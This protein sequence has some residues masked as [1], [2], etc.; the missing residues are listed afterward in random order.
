M[1]GGHHLVQQ[2]LFVSRRA[3]TSPAPAQGEQI[4]ARQAD[5][6]VR[7]VREGAV[8]FPGGEGIFDTEYRTR[9]DLANRR[10]VFELTNSPNVMRTEADKH[11]VSPGAPV[12]TLDPDATANGAGY[13]LGR[14]AALPRC[15]ETSSSF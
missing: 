12:K 13:R 10:Y 3:G 11:D 6:A 4:A 7:A 2:H 15:M 5:A 1:A 14:K 8:R 9:S